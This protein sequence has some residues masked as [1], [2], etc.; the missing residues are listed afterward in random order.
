M[1]AFY[2]SK[3]VCS[4]YFIS[5]CQYLK[6]PQCFVCH[7]ILL[8]SSPWLQWPGWH[9][10]LGIR[11]FCT[12][13]QTQLCLTIQNRFF[14]LTRLTCEYFLTSRVPVL[15][16]SV[17]LIFPL[18]IFVTHFSKIVSAD[19]SLHAILLSSGFSAR[20]LEQ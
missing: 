2:L 9:Y 5:T 6:V 12:L 10:Y 7:F 14:L 1:N 18:I 15:Y 8:K 3:G 19:A 20:L 11:I 17:T 16:S 4:G 13:T